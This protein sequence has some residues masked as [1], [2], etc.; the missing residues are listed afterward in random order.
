MTVNIKIN[1][2]PMITTKIILLESLIYH[3][4]STITVTVSD[5]LIRLPCA[6]ERVVN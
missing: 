3:T 1:I 2:I 5:K 4:S 6:R